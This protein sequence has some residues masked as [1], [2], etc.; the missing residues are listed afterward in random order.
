MELSRRRWIG[1]SVGIAAFLAVVGVALAVVFQV[2]NEIDAELVLSGVEVLSDENL[3][4]YWDRDLT[5][6][7]TFIEFRGAAFQPPLQP[8]V[9]PEWVYVQNRSDKDLTLIDP[10]RDIPG[11][12]AEDI[13]HIAGSVHNLDGDWIGETCDRDVALAPGEVVRV[14]IRVDV[15]EGV[16]PA[17]Y[18]FVAVFGAVGGEEEPP[19]PPARIAFTSDRDVNEEIY[20]MD[21][22]GANQTRLTDNPGNDAWPDWSPDGN[23]I[24]FHSNR[25]G[26][27]QVYVMD[28]DGTSQTR[29]A[30]TEFDDRYPEWSPDN[31]KIVFASD[32][33][34]AFEIYA[35]D[36][37]GTN[38]TRLTNNAVHDFYPA[39]SPDGTK[40]AF[41]GAGEIYLMD[42]DGSNPVNL[43]NDAASDAAPAW[44]PDGTKIAFRTNRNGNHE[45][46]VMGADGSNPTRLT[47]DPGVDHAPSWS[48][49]GRGIVFYSDR[50]GNAEIYVMD[51]DGSNQTRITNNSDFDAFPDWSPGAVPPPLP[52]GPGPGPD[53][54]QAPAG[55]VGWWPGDG[56]ADDIVSGNHGTLQGDATFAAGMVGQAFSLD[57]VGDWVEL[58]GAE[59]LSLTNSDFTVDAWVNLS[60]PRHID[61]VLGTLTGARNEGLHLAAAHGGQNPYMGFWFND[62]GAPTVISANTWYHLTWRYTKS[63]GEHAIFVNGT[64]DKSSTGHESFQGTGT[65]YIGRS[66]GSQPFTGLID[67]VEIFNRALSEAEIRAIY[68]AGSAGKIKVPPPPPPGPDAIQAPEGMVGWWPG[69]GNADDIVGG[70]HGT[71]QGDA[72]FATGMVGEAFSLDG[73][74]DWVEL[75]GAEALSLTNSSFTVDAWVNLSNPRHQDPVLGTR[76]NVRNEGLALTAAWHDQ[77]PLMSFWFNDLGGTAVISANT[78][79]H[80]AWRY[81]KSTGEQAIFVNG[82]LDV[83]ATGHEP[84]EGT[85]TV[86]IGRDSGRPFTGLIDE[87]EIFNRAL[88]DA[89]IKAIYNAGSAGKIKTPPPSPPPPTPTSP[90]PTPSQPPPPTRETPPPVVPPPAPVP[91]VHS[92]TDIEA[93][94]G[95]YT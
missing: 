24:A 54:I 92:N 60:N 18:P 44:S 69:D 87:V 38:Q 58:V 30:P 27:N 49:D 47:D 56:N 74:G 6:P 71:P 10:C 36:A 42:A 81:T 19:P 9:R 94:I 5:D 68:D 79:Y 12:G 57:G 80:L 28:A 40:I 53:P 77:H 48:S 1:L 61:P 45:I 11:A 34:G 31:G 65:V 7:V 91:A 64:L 78:W 37:D 88:S 13:A 51:P 52:P 33:N 39:W 82:T 83:S 25:D 21:A 29:V 59:A 35:M 76:S 17:N 43:T 23:K 55:M 67:E 66:V 50:D 15:R 14:Q 41:E 8:G 84:F 2:S 16:E 20:S 86:Y 85:G 46:Y 95:R 3:G 26:I 90:P 93:V 72:T 75:V 63:T 4:V 62:T 70:N 32:R 22:D 89:E 73:D